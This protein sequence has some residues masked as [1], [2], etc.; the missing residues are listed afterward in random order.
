MTTATM[1]SNEELNFL[2]TKTG[3]LVWRLTLGPLSGGQPQQ[4]AHDIR[5]LAPKVD[6]EEKREALLKA[7]AHLETV[8]KQQSLQAAIQ[9]L[10]AECEALKSAGLTTTQQR[11]LY[12]ILHSLAGT[13]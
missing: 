9:R 2:L 10:T 5:R 3:N 8:A 1:I 7:A 13:K 4:Q 12:Q 11:S 6:D